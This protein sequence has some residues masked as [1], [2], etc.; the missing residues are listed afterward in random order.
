V[1]FLEQGGTG[2][3]SLP[4]A[5]HALS[6]NKIEPTEEHLALAVNAFGNVADKA[7]Q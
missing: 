7:L 1:R 4:L 3:A 2:H 5:L 6:H